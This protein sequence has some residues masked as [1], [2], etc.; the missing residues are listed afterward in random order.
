MKQCLF[1]FA[2]LLQYDCLYEAVKLRHKYEFC[3]VCLSQI[4]MIDERKSLCSRCG[5][6]VTHTSICADCQYWEQTQHHIVN[7]QALF[8]YNDFTVNLLWKIKHNRDIHLIRG[9]Y[10]FI[11]RKLLQTYDFSTTVFIPIPTSEDALQWR[12]FN[13]SEF[14]FS[15]LNLPLTVLPIFMT[16]KGKVAKQHSLDRTTRLRTVKARY[17]LDEEKTGQLS[18]D[19]WKRVVLIDDVY[20]TGATMTKGIKSLPVL[21][22]HKMVSFTIFR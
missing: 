16:I 15:E 13:L 7:Q 22:S 19:K 11:K 2:N 5:N 12:G 18:A 20:T 8:R 10:P 17:V 1:C 3:T 6:K 9:F 21:D 14:I 4:E